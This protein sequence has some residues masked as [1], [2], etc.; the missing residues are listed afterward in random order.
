MKADSARRPR[1]SKWPKAKKPRGK[2]PMPVYLW[3]FPRCFI[4]RIPAQNTVPIERVAVEIEPDTAVRHPQTFFFKN[5]PSRGP[6]WGYSNHKAVLATRIIRLENEENPTPYFLMVCRGE[7]PKAQ[8][9]FNNSAVFEVDVPIFGDAFVFKLGDPELCGP[10]GYARYVDIEEG[11][12]GIEWLGQAIRMA[13]RKIESATAEYANPGFPDL[14]NYADQKTMSKDARTMHL[15]K[16][17]IR[18]ANIRLGTPISIEEA[19]RMPV[20]ESMSYAIEKMNVQI[21]AWKEQ[22]QCSRTE[23]GTKSWICKIIDAYYESVYVFDGA[24]KETR[25]A[26]PL[27]NTISDS[28]YLESSDPRMVNAVGRARGCFHNVKSAFRISGRYGEGKI[29]Q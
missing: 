20:V 22:E 3:W 17:E 11:F 26:I 21:N 24:Y 19:S 23:E 13:S 8:S 7:H 18:K 9:P 16:K 10:D 27:D 14:K 5:V 15:W 28:S 29:S 25:A 12:R 2:Q 6:F 1:L 4:L